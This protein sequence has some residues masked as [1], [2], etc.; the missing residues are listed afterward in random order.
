[1]TALLANEPKKKKKKGSSQC[2]APILS[3]NAREEPEFFM[4]KKAQ[5]EFGYTFFCSQA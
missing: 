1:L 5:L 4:T 2:L 3:I